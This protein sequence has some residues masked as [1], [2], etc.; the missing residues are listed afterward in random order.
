VGAAYGPVHRDHVDALVDVLT[1]LSPRIVFGVAQGPVHA[2]RRRLMPTHPDARLA[3]LLHLI[4]VDAFM[5]VNGPVQ[6]H[7]L[8]HLCRHAGAEG[9]RS[10]LDLYCGA[11]AYTLPLAARGISILGVER[12]GQAIEAARAAAHA[13]KLES[14]TFESAD[15][16]ACVPQ[17]V[18]AR[19]QACDLVVANPPRAGLKSAAGWLAS[20]PGHMALVSCQPASLAKD[21]TVLIA[22]GLRLRALTLFDMFPHTDH[23]ETLAWLAR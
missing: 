22:G 17:S 12:H 21:L 19:L 11:G 10:A 23:V 9:I 20:A 16:D 7:L 8:D 1:P 14:A 2:Q 15:L 18:H 13:Q 3:G 6:Q 5:Q 4:P